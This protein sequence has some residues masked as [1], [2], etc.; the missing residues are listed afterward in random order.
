MLKGE[1]LRIQ[2]LAKKN[3]EKARLAEKNDT[4][5]VGIEKKKIDAE[6]A[7][8]NAGRLFKDMKKREF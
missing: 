7:D 1:L 3:A 8:R 2:R 5:E 6:I 4:S